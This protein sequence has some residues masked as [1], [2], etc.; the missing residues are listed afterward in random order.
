[1]RSEHLGESS[2]L[3]GRIEL[4]ASPP[5][6]AEFGRVLSSKF[7]WEPPISEQAVG[8]ILRIG[9]VVRPR[10]ALAVIVDDPADDRVLEAALE[11]GAE[12]I[13]SGDRHLPR[14]GPWRGIKVEKAAPFLRS[15]H[16]V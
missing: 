16:G 11:G 14:V 6:L 15:L 10:E 7:G 9:T 3:E 1:M 4:V 13:V 2:H 5:L 12:V 8:Q